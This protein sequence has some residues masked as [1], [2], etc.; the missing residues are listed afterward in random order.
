[1]CGKKEVAKVGPAQILMR[2]CQEEVN[3]VDTGVSCRELEPRSWVG[4][5]SVSGS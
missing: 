1:V 4:L 2:T 3:T 5:S